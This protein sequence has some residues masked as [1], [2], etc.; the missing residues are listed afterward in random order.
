M[1][2]TW[3]PSQHSK[4]ICVCHILLHGKP[5][6]YRLGV[7]LR[8]RMFTRTVCFGVFQ[9]HIHIYTYIY[10]FCDHVRLT[11]FLHERYSG[12]IQ[13]ADVASLRKLE[14]TSHPRGGAARLEPNS[15]QSMDENNRCFYP[16]RDHWKIIMLLF[17]PSVSECQRNLLIQNF[18]K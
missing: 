13:Q 6:C 15:A 16:Y 18:Q 5:K 4:F 10:A 17:H 3:Q 14:R 1:P 12:G 7:T 2:Q 8:D 11:V 9:V